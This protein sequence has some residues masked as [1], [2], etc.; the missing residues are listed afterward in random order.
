LITC[1]VGLADVLH[2]LFSV[3]AVCLK[4]LASGLHGLGLDPEGPGPGFEAMAL[5]L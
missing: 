2:I 5:A 3:L 1:P 4:A